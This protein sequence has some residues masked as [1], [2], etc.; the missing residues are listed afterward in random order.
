MSKLADFQIIK[1][2]GKLSLKPN[3][4]H[5]IN[6]NVDFYSEAT[7]CLIYRCPIIII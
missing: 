5:I 6:Y 4:Q 2:L 1:K 3:S 7:T